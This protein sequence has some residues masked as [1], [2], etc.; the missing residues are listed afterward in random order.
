M[1]QQLSVSPASASNSYHHRSEAQRGWHPQLAA[2]LSVL[3]LMLLRRA[4]RAYAGSGG[5]ARLGVTLQAKSPCPL[6][7]AELMADGPRNYLIR[8]VIHQPHNARIR[9]RSHNI[10]HKLITAV[11]RFTWVHRGCQTIDICQ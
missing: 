7:P 3:V 6:T 1:S 4:G 2:K 8:D 9:R 10:G 11:E 5:V